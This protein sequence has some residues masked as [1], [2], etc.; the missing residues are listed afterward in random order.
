MKISKNPVEAFINKSTAGSFILLLFT[1]IALVW[2]NSP[3]QESYHAFFNETFSVGFSDT[4]YIISKPLYLWINDG[5]M[6]IFFFYVGLEIKRE[7]LDGE[8]TSMRK[9]TM[10]VFAALG[11]IIVPIVIFLLLHVEERGTAGWG[12]PMATD[13]AFSLGILNL[14]GNRVPLSLKIFLT[15]FAIIDD[16]GAILVIAIFYSHEMHFLYLGIALAILVFL[17][18]LMFKKF[19]SKYLLL[20]CSIAIWILFLKSGVHP[21]IA[22]V[23]IAMVI[24][25]TRSVDLDNFFDEIKKSLNIFKET[26]MRK[27]ILSHEQQ[28]AVDQINVITDRVQSP[29]QQ[30]EH[31]LS[32]WVTI[33]IMPIF[34]LANAGITIDLDSLSQTQLISQIAIA[35]VVGKVVG[36][37]AFSWFAYKLNIAT[38]P[39]G[40]GF[41]EIFGVSFLGGVGFT[42]SLFIA[43]LAFRANDL[44]TSSKIGILVGTL[45]A[46]L[47][48]YFILH[49]QLKKKAEEKASIPN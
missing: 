19:H 39:T 49:Y 16:I 18:F 40:I 37:T 6:T 10:P 33:V 41:R 8:L 21:T 26:E 32:G 34:A 17:A 14:L 4:A 48:G 43:E 27:V 13:I 36:I 7:V 11:G 38:L 20:I 3:W 28:E 23:L 15:A 24:P 1:I 35:L 31:G 47:A 30:L 45:V 44:L 42:M 2:A 29:M 46:G 22:G 5:L 25:A 9:A 12:I